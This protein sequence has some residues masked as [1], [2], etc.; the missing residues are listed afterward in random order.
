MKL[1]NTLHIY[2]RCGASLHDAGIQNI[3]GCHLIFLCF[4]KPVP[5]TKTI[6]RRLIHTGVLG[7]EMEKYVH[8]YRCPMV[9]PKC[10]C[11]IYMSP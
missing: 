10:M 3:D 1:K 5:K 6:Q 4:V 7:R 9:L 11:F 2:Y 8:M